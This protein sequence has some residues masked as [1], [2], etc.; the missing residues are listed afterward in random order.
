MNVKQKLHQANLAKWTALFHEQAS[1]GLTIKNWCARIV[2]FAGSV[3]S[4]GSAVPHHR[5]W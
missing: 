2:P 1:S 4:A 3:Q 5:H